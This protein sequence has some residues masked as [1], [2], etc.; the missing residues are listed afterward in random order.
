MKQ[1][2]TQRAPDPGRAPGQAGG[3]RRVF[4]QFLWLG[5][6]FVKGALPRPAHQRVTRAVRRLKD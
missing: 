4:R 5:A 1:R 2:L 3:S 6:G